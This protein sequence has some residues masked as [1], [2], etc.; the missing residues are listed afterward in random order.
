MLA[1]IAAA[2]APAPT[3][4]AVKAVIDSAADAANAAT[5]AIVTQSTMRLTEILRSCS[6]VSST[7][8]DSAIVPSAATSVSVVD[9]AGGILAE[10]PPDS[11][12]PAPTGAGRTKTP[13]GSGFEPPRQPANVA[14]GTAKPPP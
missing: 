14:A 9:A 5:T 10:R 4:I 12:T 11:L 2:P 3:A 7:A 6:A 13:V 1:A 8:N